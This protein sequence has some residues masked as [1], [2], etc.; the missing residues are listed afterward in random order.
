MNGGKVDDPQ[1]LLFSIV[2]CIGC[3][4]IFFREV[5]DTYTAVVY[6]MAIALEHTTPG[7][8]L[9]GVDHLICLGLDA[10]IFRHVPGRPPSC[11]R[12]AGEDKD[13]LYVWV[14]ILHV[15][16]SLCGEGIKAPRTSGSIKLDALLNQANN[17]FFQLHG[18]FLAESRRQLAV[19]CEAAGSFSHFTH[20]LYPL[21][22][23]LYHCIAINGNS[24]L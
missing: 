3:P 1:T 22:A 5:A 2:H 6:Q 10:L 7:V 8:L 21:L 16:Y 20:S 14:S 24:P 13:Q 12:Q 11:L 19:A 15:K 9:G 18:E 17:R 23:V 4:T